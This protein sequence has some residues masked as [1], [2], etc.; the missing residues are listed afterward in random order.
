MCVERFKH[1][2]CFVLYLSFRW[3]FGLM[4]VADLK[5]KRIMELH[6]FLNIWHSRF[7]FFSSFLCQPSLCLLIDM[8]VCQLH[9]HL[10]KSWLPTFQ[11]FAQIVGRTTCKQLY[12]EHRAQRIAHRWIWSSRWRI[13][14]HI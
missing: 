7:V 9:V 6:I 11:I 5:Q 13:W 8:S 3:V 4:Q 14:E 2:V 10:H 12:T 1:F